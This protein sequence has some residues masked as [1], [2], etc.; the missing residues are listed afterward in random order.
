M[1]IDRTIQINA[2]ESELICGFCRVPHRVCAI[3]ELFFASFNYH[4]FSTTNAASHIV[5]VPAA[6]TIDYAMR[7]EISKGMEK[8]L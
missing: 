7:S 2:S 8:T 5:K 4:G 6:A 1:A 3:N